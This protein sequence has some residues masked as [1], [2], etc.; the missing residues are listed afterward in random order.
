MHYERGASDGAG[1]FAE[2]L[3]AAMRELGFA[4]V[5]GQW[6]RGQPAWREAPQ[7]Q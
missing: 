7:G 5:L 2:A 1:E 3:E 6:K 4:Y